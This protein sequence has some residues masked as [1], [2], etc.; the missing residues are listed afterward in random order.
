MID[1]EN[2]EDI[3]SVIDEYG[4]KEL[5]HFTSTS[6][7]WGISKNGLSNL[8]NFD[9]YTRANTKA[10]D[11]KNKANEFISL[12]ISFPNYKMLHK[13]RK[14]EE[15]S[16]YI[17]DGKIKGW[18]I[19]SI[20]PKVLT[21]N[22]C[23]FIGANAGGL[24]KQDDVRNYSWAKHL[25]AMF[26]EEVESKNS[27]RVVKRYRKLP[28]NYTT[29]PQA[30]VLVAGVIPNE[31]IKKIYFEKQSC[32]DEAKEFFKNKVDLLERFEVRD[33]L[34]MPRMDWK[35]WQWN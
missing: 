9:G 26:L 8:K 13:K 4:I 5:V 34:F 29:N 14:T 10:S 33:E 1:Q 7:L 11:G 28:K 30:E 20:D 31:Y 24:D 21:E 23:Y 17:N 12:S 18:V 27:K 35:A 3:Q 25:Q 32:L 19:L 6:N 16:F 2:K 15:N 22:E